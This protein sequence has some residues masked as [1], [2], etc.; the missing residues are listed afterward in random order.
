MRNTNNN[1]N[2][3]STEPAPSQAI[4]L[5]WRS[6]PASI[7]KG[8]DVIWNNQ[9]GDGRFAVLGKIV[10]LANVYNNGR[11]VKIEKA[12]G[13]QVEIR[14]TEEDK[15]YLLEEADE[16][17]GALHVTIQLDAPLSARRLTLQTGEVV[18]SVVMPAHIINVELAPTT[19]ESDVF[20]TEEEED[21]FWSEN[22]ARAQESLSSYRAG[23]AAAK[24]AS[25][26]AAAAEVP[27][28]S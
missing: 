27:Q 28:L 8:Q 20:E 10:D 15:D 13:G 3:F 16:I 24:Q 12:K 22:Q 5:V 17:K 6:T 18:P 4:L 19:L 2:P 23:L 7:E 26:E 21:N 1:Q 14:L 25:E 11:L 9:R